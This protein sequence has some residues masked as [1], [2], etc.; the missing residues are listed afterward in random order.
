RRGRY[1]LE[2][3]FPKSRYFKGKKNPLFENHFFLTIPLM[4]ENE[5]VGVLNLNDCQ[6]GYFTV[7]DL[8]F[9]LNVAEFISLS[10]N[11]ALSYEKAERLSVTD[12]LTGLN[13]HQQ[14]E[15]L[16][17]RE[18]HR[19]RR[20]C[21]PLSLI[22]LDIDHFKRIND[23]YGHQ[24]GDE[25]LIAVASFLE[26]MC[27]ENDIAA[28]YGGEEFVLILPETPSSGAFQIA[29]RLR[30][31]ISQRCFPHEKGDYSI[32]L[33]G[34]ISEFDA[35]KMT[36]HSDLIRVADQALYQAKE[37]GRN[38]TVTLRPDDLPQD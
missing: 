8:D 20:Y 37:S 25:V 3:D 11:N 36:D 21:S 7:S 9:A 12:G 33:S 34:G 23:T 13:N 5:I 31:T 32:T 16:L 2:Q 26:E 6:A 22:I 30:Q 29:E 19:S 27:R 14:M 18:V 35:E 15:T 28:R 4:I 10:I 38:C 24:A 17:R 1:I